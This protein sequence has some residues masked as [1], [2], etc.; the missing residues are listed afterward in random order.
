MQKIVTAA[1]LVIGDEILSGRTLDTN[2]QVI[3]TM[4]GAI[5]I[6]I[7]DVRVVPDDVAVIAKTVNDLRGRFDYLFSTGG[8]GPTHDDKTAEAMAQAFGVTLERNAEAWARLVAHYDG[9]EHMNAGRSK[10]ADIPAGAVLIDN[11]VSAAPG[12]ILGNVYV[13]AGV[14]KIMKAMLEGV[15]P[16]LSGGAVIH[17]RSIECGVAESFLAEM[18]AAVEAA[19]AGV[20]VGSYP[21][22]TPNQ[23]PHTTIVIRGADLSVVEAAVVDLRRSLENLPLPPTV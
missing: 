8:I 20:S 7:R 22:F 15:L 4:L 6:Q 10:M 11:P 18:L 3:A 17:S 23:K 9:P 13:M 14:P 16:K 2:T 1:V 12:F 19:H 5:G 21:K